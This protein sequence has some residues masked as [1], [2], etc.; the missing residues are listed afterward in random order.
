MAGPGR[1]YVHEKR[2]AMGPAGRECRVPRDRAKRFSIGG[3]GL[4]RDVAGILPAEIIRFGRYPTI[5]SRPTQKPAFSTFLSTLPT[6]V[7]GNSVTNLIWF[8]A[9]AEHLL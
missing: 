7:I 4:A 9:C 2:A 6:P 8:G 5:R 3:Q 1:A